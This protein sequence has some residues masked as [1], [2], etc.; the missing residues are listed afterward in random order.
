MSDTPGTPPPQKD[1][2]KGGFPG[3]PTRPGDTEP[4]ATRPVRS[5]EELEH[6]HGQRQQRGTKR[7]RRIR[8]A[9][10]TVAVLALGGAVGFA[11]GVRS[12]QTQEELT[13]AAEKPASASQDSF[14]SQEVN[15][16]LLE[17]WKMEDVEM[18]RNRGRIP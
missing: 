10:G 2:I 6:A 13:A 15:R 8:R 1:R 4:P 14:I 18:Q 5:V 17:L 7:R 9:W 12:H 3:G 16:T 11:L